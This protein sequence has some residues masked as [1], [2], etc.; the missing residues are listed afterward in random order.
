MGDNNLCEYCRKKPRVG[1]FAGCED[2]LEDAG[3]SITSD[4]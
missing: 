1:S 2:C 3:W 4:P